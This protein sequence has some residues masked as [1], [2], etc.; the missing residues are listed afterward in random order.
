VDKR[1]E[2]I[3]QPFNAKTRAARPERE[4]GMDKIWDI[5]V[6]GAG[7]AGLST[8]IFAASEGLD[9][10][11]IEHKRIGGQSSASPLIENYYGFPEGISGAELAYRGKQ[12]AKRLGATIIK[13]DVTR[14]LPP[15]TKGATKQLLLADGQ[16]IE[17]R[18]VVIA[19][20]LAFKKLPQDHTDCQDIYYGAC[21]GLAYQYANQKVIVVGAGNSAG[22]AV[23]H[24]AQLNAEVTLLVR[25]DR[26][27]DSMSD[28]LVKRV[29]QNPKVKIL[30]NTSIEGFEVN[31]DGS[32]KGVRTNGGFIEGAACF[33]F[34][35]AGPDTSWCESCVQTDKTGFVLVDG[36][37]KT[38]VEGVYAIGDVRQGSRGRVAAA[39]GEGS[40]VVGEI[41]GYLAENQSAAAA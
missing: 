9:T 1:G 16:V 34:I 29:H 14:I 7:P 12:Q 5:V 39:V 18:C 20:G 4:I 38:S 37:Y 15:E 2:S 33:V 11:V 41:H 30:F 31:T 24:L 22:Q 10:L 28:Y 8:G 6:V 13:A 25:G 26:I 23:E 32:L 17:S 27:E 21:A 19:C 35:G 36:S 40:V 3:P